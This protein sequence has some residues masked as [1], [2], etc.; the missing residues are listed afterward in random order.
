M[1]YWQEAVAL[2]NHV[3]RVGHGDQQHSPVVTSLEEVEQQA[4]PACLRALHV[5]LAPHDGPGEHPAPA[6]DDLRA[7]ADALGQAVRGARLWSSPHAGAWACVHPTCVRLCA[8]GA[9]PAETTLSTLC[10]QIARLGAVIQADLG[11]ISSSG[12]MAGDM[13]DILDLL[14]LL[15]TLTTD[16]AEAPPSAP[17]A[18]QPQQQQAPAR[19][20]AWDPSPSHQARGWSNACG[21]AGRVHVKG[22]ASRA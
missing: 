6:A 20:G 17:P 18:E 11:H 16:R 21:R 7:M 14:E 4:A 5:V 15:A 10:T 22:T 1:A 3:L 12:I 13:G 19:A 9:N 2:C 8:P